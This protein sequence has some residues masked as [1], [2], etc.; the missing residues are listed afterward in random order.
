MRFRWP[1]FAA[2]VIFSLVLGSKFWFAEAATS[3]QNI[4]VGYTVPAQGGIVVV[5]PPPPINPP[6]ITN[7]ASST[8]YTTAN[9]SWSANGSGGISAS[10]F[11]YGLT[12]GYGSS[13]TV[14]GNYQVNLTNLATGTLYYFKISATDSNSQTSNF[15]DSFVTQAAAPSP[16]IT[17]PLISNIQVDTG[18]TTSTITW[19]TDELADSQVNYGTTASYGT[20]SLDSTKTLSHSI[21]LSSLV[22]NTT[23]HYRVVS[24]DAAGNSA[25]STDL[26]FKTLKDNTTPPDVS[27]IQVV[28]NPGSIA[29]SWTNPPL[30]TVPDFSGVKVVRKVDSQSATVDDG[31]LVYTGSGE[32][33]TDSSVLNNVNYFYTIFSFDTS[34]NYSPGTFGNAKI[35]PPPSQEICNNGVDD[36]NNGLIDCADATCI[37]DPVC[38]APT[39]EICN[40]GIDDNNNGLTDC[41]DAACIGDASCRSLRYE[42]CNNGVDDD[43]NGAIDCADSA[44]FG[45]SGCALNTLPPPTYVPPTSTVPNFVKINASDV[46]FFTGNRK[47]RLTPHNEE[48]A[49]LAGFP[50]TITLAKANLPTTPLALTV[51]VDG[52]DQH[53]FVYDVAT[54]SYYSTIIFPIIGSHQLS[55]EVDYGAGQLDSI[56]FKILSQAFGNIFDSNGSVDQAEVTLFNDDNNIFPAENF[57]ERNP[58]L[59]NVNGTYG[60]MV[61]NGRYSVKVVKGGYY[62]RSLPTFNVDNNTINISLN[63]IPKPLSLAE[64]IDSKASLQKNVINLAK[65]LVE[66]SQAAIALTSQTV[67]D[68]ARAVQEAAKNPEVQKV[69]SQIVAPT[70]VS[71]ATVSSIVLISWV[72]FLPFLRLLFLQPL[73]LLGLRKREKWGQV[74]NA[75]NKLPVDLATIRLINAD[76]GKIIQSKVTDRKGRYAFVLDP[77]NYRLQVYKGGMLFPSAL[78]ADFKSDGRRLDIY[79]GEVIN[80]KEDDA[81]IT[82]SIP[83]DPVG[84]HKKPHRLAIERFGRV[85]QKTLSW[86]GLVVNLVSLYIAPRWY[87]WVLLGI[88]LATSFL[89]S[90]LAKPPKV[91]SWGIVYDAGNKKPITQAVARLFSSQFNKLVAT[92]VTDRRG[93]YYFLAGDNQF[94]VTY[95]HATYA[96][97]KSE[98]IDLSGKDAETIAV[99]VGLSKENKS[100]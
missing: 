44:C 23:Y 33:L 92:Q 15:T 77:G 79:H 64:S 19:T 52:Q 2:I 25:A 37:N 78:L 7:V 6:T 30:F 36:N 28:A 3:N 80:V 98:I 9:V 68:T 35:I 70:A 90:R 40:N 76:T 49:G 12:T 89:F 31:T 45:F 27:N 51:K 59:T 21:F 17:P 26:T 94:Y 11:V 69:T 87:V 46:A 57:G 34:L 50:L 100:A 63:L 67:V 56:Q 85:L 43:G 39:P 4:G 86:V 29:V 83:L 97:Q 47:I 62:T 24:A 54:D 95:E 73:M 8:T 75:L 60:W 38:K 18:A 1:V 48:V 82:A 55:I 20:N 22:P 99:N 58:I 96:P 10:A 88:H 93:R 84:E 81:V 41:A 74:Y 16:D 53:Q 14:A 5:N 91:K 42:I 72:D 71:V 61:P 65:N 13:A 32:T 66:Q